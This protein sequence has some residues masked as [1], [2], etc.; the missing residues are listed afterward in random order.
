[1]GL[2]GFQ[3]GTTRFV[4]MRTVVEFTFR[5]ETENIGKIV[6]NLGPLHLNGSKAL[7]ARSVDQ[8]ASLGQGDHCGEGRGVHPFIM[9]L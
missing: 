5:G 1:M 9:I 8:V 7:D 6:G 2:Y 3:Y 4:A